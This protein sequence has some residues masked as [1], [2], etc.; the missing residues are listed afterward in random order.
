MSKSEYQKI[1]E[2]FLRPTLIENGFHEIRLI[3]LIKPEILYRKNDLWFGTSWDRRDQ[4]LDISLGHLY[5]FKDFMPR[6]VVVGDYSSYSH[7]IDRLKKT[8]ED[9]LKSVV[10]KIGETLPDAMEIYKDRYNLI[11]EG[12]IKKRSRLVDNFEEYLI[13]KATDQSLNKY[14]A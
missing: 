4:Y 14:W 2:K 13:G 10:S 8:N 12:Y 3:N 9:F 7:E 11:F 1:V 5:W 6:I